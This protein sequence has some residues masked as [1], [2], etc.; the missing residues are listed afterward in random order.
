MAQE[1]YDLAID[2]VD[3]SFT[4]LLSYLSGAQY[5][6]WGRFRGEPYS[7]YWASRLPDGRWADKVIFRVPTRK[8]LCRV[9]HL[10]EV[11]RLMGIPAGEDIKPRI[12]LSQE[13]RKRGRAQIRKLC[14]RR[15][16]IIAIQP[17]GHHK[18][19]LW[20][21]RNY[22]ALCDR[23]IEELDA[24]VLIF[25]GPREETAVKRVRSA[26]KHLLPV[27]IPKDLRQYFSLVS[28][29][30]IFIS[31]D[32]GP[33]HMALALDVASVGIFKSRIIQRYWYVPHYRGFLN[34]VFLHSAKF[35]ENRAGVDAVFSR[36]AKLL[37]KQRAGTGK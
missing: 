29:A 24:Q 36:V 11:T 20:G 19:R 37:R 2:F 12:Y 30:D 17:G 26:C 7:L 4:R 21:W 10:F 32:G 35:R 28:Q 27:M 13:E 18:Y 9:E 15:R 1:P 14:G 23:L 3:N 16:P 33:L 34:P 5:R 8:K 22:S 31:T 6:I 25:Q